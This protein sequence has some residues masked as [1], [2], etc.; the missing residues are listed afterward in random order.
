MSRAFETFTSPLSWQQLSL[1]LDTVQ[2]F[3]DAP[4]WLSIPNEQ[5]A[6]VAVPMTAETLRA[7][8]GCVREEDAFTRVPFSLDWEDGS[9]DGKGVLVVSLP[10]GETV[11]QLTVLSMF[12]QV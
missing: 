9:E 8:L 1:L 2:Y 10:N 6:S 12:S 5:G 11:R 4:K 7:M 3:E